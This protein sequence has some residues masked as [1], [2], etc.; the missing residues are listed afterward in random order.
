MKSKTRH[1]VRF[2]NVIEDMDICSSIRS[3]HHI[4]DSDKRLRS[5]TSFTYP[6]TYESQEETT[7]SCRRG[8]RRQVRQ[9]R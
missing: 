4:V 5:S 2:D 7:T 1:T 9:R 6:V 3:F 8:N